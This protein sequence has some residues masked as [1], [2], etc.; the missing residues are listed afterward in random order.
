MA[1]LLTLILLPYIGVFLY[2]TFS[3]R[4]FLKKARK[5]AIEMQ[6]SA[7]V[8]P[9]N[10]LAIQLNHILQTNNIAGASNNNQVSLYEK[11]DEAFTAFLSAIEQAQTHI[12]IET[13]I[14]ELDGTGQQ[15]LNALIKKAKQGVEVCL[16]LDALGSFNL[17]INQKKLKPLK[18]AGGKY[19]FFQPIWSSIFSAQA[20]LR[21]HRKIYLFDQTTLFTGGMN[22]SDDYLGLKRKSHQTQ[23]WVDLMFKIKGPIT[24]H[25]Q[26]LFNDDW[27]YAT[28]EKLRQPKP[29]LSSITKEGEMMQAVPSGPDIQEDALYES[30][31]NSLY[32]A[33]QKILIVT[34][35]F[36]PDNAIMK[37][38]LIAIKRGIEVTLLT[39]ATSDHLIFDL[40]RSSYM[41]ELAEA[42]GKIHLFKNNML[43]SKLIIIDK[44]AAIIGSA[45]FDY[46]SLFINHEIVNFVYSETLI[47]TLLTWVGK[48]LE[49]SDDYHSEYSRTK[50][51]LE[52]L[53]RIFA[54]IL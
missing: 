21:N 18:I 27:Q 43:H 5:P 30:L 10:N 17:Y 8:K 51:L 4:K 31:L 33:K 20:N 52:N 39:P 26:N 50:R 13:Y 6:P 29:S 36:I 53:T 28:Q 37:A 49:Q 9:E 7:H 34:P 54:P 25:Y 23:R 32:F 44:E 11:D 16:L 24:F 15:I 12:H 35:Y 19:R 40:G 42:G 3:S 48:Q 38:L 2:L 46:R 1:W 14:F 47:T 41:R 45:N 22:L